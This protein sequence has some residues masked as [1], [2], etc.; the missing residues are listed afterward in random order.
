MIRQ[1]FDDKV[2]NG[3]LRFVDVAGEGYRGRGDGFE[4]QDL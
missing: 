1:V 3:S 4:R 2:A